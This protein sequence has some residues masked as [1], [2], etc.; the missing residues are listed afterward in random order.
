MS[1]TEEREAKERETHRTYVTPGIDVSKLKKEDN[2]GKYK[3]RT[4][5]F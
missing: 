1:K 4:T 2:V 5:A 3:T